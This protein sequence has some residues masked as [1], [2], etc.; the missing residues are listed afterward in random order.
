MII[1]RRNKPWEILKIRSACQSL[2]IFVGDIR[3]RIHNRK[4]IILKCNH[5]INIFEHSWYARS[6]NIGSFLGVIMHHEKKINLSLSIQIYLVNT[7]DK[8]SRCTFLEEYQEY[9]RGS[10]IS[11]ISTD[12]NWIIKTVFPLV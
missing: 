12:L 2:K 11:D 3:R 8:T 10:C 9:L 6:N 4:Y 5:E 1:C 7:P